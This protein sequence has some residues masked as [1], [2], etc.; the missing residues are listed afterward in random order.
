MTKNCHICWGEHNSAEY[1]AESA[2]I[3]NDVVDALIALC[4]TDDDKQKLKE[5]GFV[6]NA[7][8]DKA[9]NLSFAERKVNLVSIEKT[10]STLEE[11]FLADVEWI[12]GRKQKEYVEKLKKAVEE[13]DFATLAT[14][15]PELDGEIAKKYAD[16]MKQLFE[17]GKK[18]ASDEMQVV[19]PDT[20]KDVRGLYRAQAIAMENK[21]ET[22]MAV[23]GQSEALYQMA[24]GAD[25]AFTLA[26][27]Q[28]A[29]DNKIGK[30]VTASTTQAMYGAFNTGRLTVFEK[31]RSKIYAFQYT[32]VLDRRTTNL[33]LSLNGRVIAPEDAD[34]YR[35]SPPN[36]IN[37][38]SFWVEILNDEFIKPAIEWIPDSIP[39]ERTGLT[40]FQDLQKIIPYKPKSAMTPD[41][42]RIQREGIL[43][44]LVTDL[45]TKGVKL[46]PMSD[47]QS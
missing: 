34:F 15:K 47:E 28:K 16:N 35:L 21:F 3:T 9:G 37:C 12:M 40:N 32:A 14:L 7:Y 36:H 39:R 46:K 17:T 2:Y 4:E 44:A 30:M 25:D 10:F 23:T 41:E 33:C 6:K 27:V 31:Y 13:R 8:E 26:M 19:A 29:L 42:E 45:R 5:L 38:R 18:T 43:R 24:R 20:D 11:S 22:E 1:F